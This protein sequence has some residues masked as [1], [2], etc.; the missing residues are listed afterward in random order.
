MDFVQQHLVWREQLNKLVQSKNNLMQTGQNNILFNFFSQAIEK[1]FLTEADSFKTNIKELMLT[2]SVVAPT[3][4]GSYRTRSAH[5]LSSIV[6]ESLFGQIN[7]NDI[8]NVVLFEVYKRC[9]MFSDTYF[10]RYSSPPGTEEQNNLYLS[11]AHGNAKCTAVWTEKLRFIITAFVILKR[12]FLVYDAY[13]G[14]HPELNYT[15]LN[16]FGTNWV[17]HIENKN[18]ADLIWNIFVDLWTYENKQC[19]QLQIEKV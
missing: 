8:R 5:V 10:E 19:S 14:K 6:T 16:W 7:L 18:L 2:A 12:F 3:L 13:E 11:I 9:G 17:A 1:E 15:S 4:T